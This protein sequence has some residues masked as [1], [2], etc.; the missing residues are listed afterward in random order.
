MYTK[1]KPGILW[2]GFHSLYL[3]W[4]AVNRIDMPTWYK[5]G[6]HY[7]PKILN[8][9]ALCVC[10]GGQRGAQNRLADL[11]LPGLGHL[12]RNSRSQ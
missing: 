9:A 1:L 5:T 6:E 10:G 2:I 12:R 11:A 7:Q 4:A 3:K 8:L